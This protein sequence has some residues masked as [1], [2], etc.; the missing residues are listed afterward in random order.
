[1]S[2]IIMIT[3]FFFTL[4]IGMYFFT[5]LKGEHSDTRTLEENSKKEAERLNDMRHISLAEPLTEAAR[6]R[7]IEEIVGQ[8]DALKAMKAALCGPN[9]QHILIYGSPG[10]GKTAA[11]RLALECAKQSEGT[12]FKS[13]AKFIEVDATI[14]RYDERS[15]A[16]PLI[17]SVHD[18]IYQGAGAYGAAGVPQPKEGAVSKAHG[19]VLFIDEI[20]ELQQCQ[21]NKLLKVLEDRRVM[22]ESAYYSEGSKN[23]PTYIHDI[24]R[25]GIPADFRLIGA[26]TRKSEEIPEAIR[27]RCVEIYFN[28]LTR[29]QIA[30]IVHN[31]CERLNIAID[32]GAVELISKYAGSG[33][34]AV[35]ILQMAKNI[36]CLDGKQRIGIEDAAWTLNVCHYTNGHYFGADEKIIDISVIKPKEKNS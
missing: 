17:G 6:P 5:K 34:D 27:S 28:S 30:S 20:G 11:A 32:N 21:I 7:T 22:F 19:G 13:D 2:G 25:N 12:P 9:P 23:I 8:E 33:R 3:Q 31:T 24:F 18:P 29:E 15:I 14:M 1:M 4:V 36:I 16:D 10:V 35:K 26:T